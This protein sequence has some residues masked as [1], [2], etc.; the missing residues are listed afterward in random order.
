MQ[1]MQKNLPDAH[2]AAYPPEVVWKHAYL[3]ALS[4]SLRSDLKQHVAVAMLRNS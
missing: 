1:L 3:S 2:A 4:P